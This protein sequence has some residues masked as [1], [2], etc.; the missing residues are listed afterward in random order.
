MKCLSNAYL[1]IACANFSKHFRIPN[2]L[3]YW[4]WIVPDDTVEMQMVLFKMHF[5]VVYGA[6]YIE[7]IIF[8]N[9]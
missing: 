7:Y 4:G 3:N 6:Y 8:K 2:K 9:N 5:K 1:S